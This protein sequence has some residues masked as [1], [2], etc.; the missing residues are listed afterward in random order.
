MKNACTRARSLMAT[1]LDGDIAPA[2]AAELK[3]HLLLCAHCHE[4]LGRLRRSVAVLAALP[5]P[6]PGPTFVATTLRKARL[7]RQAQ[8]LRQQRLWQLASVAALALGAVAL[9]AIR[10]SGLWEWLAQWILTS[11][12]SVIRLC[13][14]LAVGVRSVYD[15]LAPFVRGLLL[16]LTDTLEPLLTLS[17]R[18]G[19]SAW[20]SALPGYVLAIVTLSLLAALSRSRTVAGPVQVEK[21]P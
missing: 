19:R 15:S 12:P 2:Q 5:L 4:E 1:E 8:Q 21:M 10:V 13:D 20:S 18:A 11:A 3:R 16:A 6:E 7:A 17:T 9:V 14:R